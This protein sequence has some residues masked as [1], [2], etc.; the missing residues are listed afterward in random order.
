MKF[1]NKQHE[2]DFKLLMKEVYFEITKPQLAFLYLISYYQK[3]YL[4]FEG[5]CFYIEALEDLEIG[6]P[7]YL[8]EEAVGLVMTFHMRR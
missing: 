7:T 2:Q 5:E 1:I 4:K 3:D 6:G 8:F